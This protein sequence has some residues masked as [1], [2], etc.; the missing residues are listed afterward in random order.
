MDFEKGKRCHPCQSISGNVLFV[1]IVQLQDSQRFLL[2]W[3]FCPSP[4]IATV[5]PRQ[6]S[7]W[8]HG[9]GLWE[10]GYKRKVTVT[11]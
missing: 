1:A 7:Q 2:D 11:E 6:A 5:T 9:S 8:G 3:R 4:G 10:E